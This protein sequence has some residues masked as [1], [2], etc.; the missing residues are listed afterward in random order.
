[1]GGNENVLVGVFV[2]VRECIY[3]QPLPQNIRVRVRAESQ[4]RDRGESRERK[5]NPS[6]KA[7]Y[8]PS[9]FILYSSVTINTK[10]LTSYFGLFKPQQFN[11]HL[12][13]Q[14]YEHSSEETQFNVRETI[15][16]HVKH[17]S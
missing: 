4:E 10:K 8:H 2:D 15:T 16:F 5:S 7:L 11:Q 1:M 17:H 9:P 14:F 6:P 12:S 3:S 13:G